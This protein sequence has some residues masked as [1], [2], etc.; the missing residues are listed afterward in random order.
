ML[1]IEYAKHGIPNGD[2]LSEE[3]AREIYKRYSE[4][5]YT[6]DYT[7]QTSTDGLVTAFRML[8]AEGDI[9]HDKIVFKFNGEIIKVINE[10]GE[11][12]RWNNGFADAEM[13]ML[14]RIVQVRIKNR[15]KQDKN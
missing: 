5:G 10:L 13:G 12:E 15:N 2:L 1:I 9:P 3:I 8:V 4:S 11:I 6:D 14:R 7:Y